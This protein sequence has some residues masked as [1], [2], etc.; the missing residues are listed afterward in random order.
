MI[1]VLDESV[2]L[3]EKSG[4]FKEIGKSGH[5][6]SGSAEATARAKAV[7][8]MKS[9]T[10]LTMSQAIDEVLQADPEL[11]ERFEEED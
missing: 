4:L 11:R 3:V 8:L 9:K 1:S 2:A 10:D 5:G 6:N 7:E